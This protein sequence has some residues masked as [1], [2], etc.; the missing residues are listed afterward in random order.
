MHG[1]FNKYPVREAAPISSRIQA[2]LKIQTLS[3]ARVLHEEPP[4]LM[5]RQDPTTTPSQPLQDIQIHPCAPSVSL[6]LSLEDANEAVAVES[7]SPSPSTDP[8]PTAAMAEMET[9]KPVAH[10]T[11]PPRKEPQISATNLPDQHLLSQILSPS[12][13][14]SFDDL[15]EQ[16]SARLFTV[17][18]LM[19]LLTGSKTNKKDA[20]DKG[21]STPLA[22]ALETLAR[23][24]AAVDEGEVDEAPKSASLTTTS[25]TA[26]S[27]SDATTGAEE[28]SGQDKDKTNRDQERRETAREA[29]RVKRQQQRRRAALEAQLQR[30]AQHPVYSQ[31]GGIGAHLYSS[32]PT[33]SGPFLLYQSASILAQGPGLITLNPL[34]AEF[35]PRISELC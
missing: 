24:A 3:Y 2:S 4:E 1:M 21:L 19:R 13:Q 10:E 22:L 28:A 9:V 6:N 16:I 17:E 8:S 20:D 26:L 11:S 5:G 31:P 34:A 29:R 27:D 33:G 15:V 14:A 25:L 32:T 7:I 18:N 30:Q 35:V 23:T 12:P